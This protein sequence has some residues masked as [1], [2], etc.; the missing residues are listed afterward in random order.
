MTRPAAGVALCVL[1]ASVAAAQAPPVYDRRQPVERPVTTTGPG[2]QKLAVDVPLMA[3]AKPFVPLAPAEGAQAFGGLGDLRL[4][5][6][7]GR[8]I[9]YLLIVPPTHTRVWHRGTIL[10]VAGTTKTSGFEVDLGAPRLVGELAFDGI[11]APFLKRFLLEGSGDRA[12]WTMLVGEG[13][14]FDLPA[15]RVRQTAVAF[16]PGTYRY[17]RVTWDDTNSGRVGLPRRAEAADVAQRALPDPLRVPV[18]IERQ[19]SEPG[20]SRYRLRLPAARLPVVAILLDPGPAD[21]FRT[22]TVLESR[23]AGV[24]A[25]PVEVGR[26]RLVR[27]RTGPSAAP[28][29]LPIQEPQGSEL[30]LVVDD[31]NNPPLEFASASIEFA[32]L[33]WIYFEAPGGVVTARY[34]SPTARAPRYD[35]EAKRA[36]V[37]LASLPEAQ[38]GVPRQ[39]EAAGTAVAAPALPERGAQLDV[40]PFKYRR[41]LSEVGAGLVSLQLDA[42]VL[43]HSRGPGARFADVRVADNDGFQIPYLLERRDEPL[44]I[45]LP[46]RKGASSA[47]SRAGA[48]AGQR[49][50]HALTL[51]FADLPA[52]RLVLETSDRVFR[53]PLQVAIE[54][55]P[56][57]THRD[58]WLEVLASPVWQHADQGSPAV[59]LEAAISP[60]Q[61]TELVVIVDEGDNTPLTL[62]AA[63]LLLPSWRARFFRPSGPLQLI[64]GNEAVA[65]PEYDLA[66]LAPAVLGADAREITAAAETTAVSTPGAVL[67]PRLFWVGLGVA[68]LVLVALIVRLIAAETRP[69]S[70]GA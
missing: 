19:A 41:R 26:A 36:A 59:P 57:R 46:I 31:G 32:V 62:T 68:V 21:V 22:A 39:A 20:R 40:A 6:A 2:P 5:D 10:P 48:T 28:L 4:F 42:A 12:H 7:A 1:V 37:D 35:L 54:R 38:W 49:S 43:A 11:P 47:A 27:Q 69:P 63:R 67:S 45:D 13:T 56:D 18:T 64:Y 29:R 9:A 70:A 23:F 52:A 3:G 34:G 44:A 24:R 51:P 30:Q 55:Q 53:R 61:A 14:L 66:L 25:D 17:L 8:E 60:R 33:P 58:P 65:V 50:V 15:E 16:V